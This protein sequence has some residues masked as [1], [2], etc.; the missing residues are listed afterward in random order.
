MTVKIALESSE[1]TQ[2]ASVLLGSEAIAEL[3]E[4]AQVEEA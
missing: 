2:W 4:T 1:H 3:E